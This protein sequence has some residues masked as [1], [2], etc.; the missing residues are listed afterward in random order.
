M[1]EKT[2][3]RM[4]E[5]QVIN[6]LSIIANKHGAKIIEADLKQHWIETDCPEESK[7]SFAV[8]VGEFLQDINVE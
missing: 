8:E 4:T 7:V 1:A 2:N 3:K 6:I 5:Q